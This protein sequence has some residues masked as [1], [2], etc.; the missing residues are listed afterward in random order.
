MKKSP[1]CSLALPLLALALCTGVSAQTPAPKGPP[2]PKINLPALSPT[3]SVKQ[4][5][6]LGDIAIDYARPSVKGRKIFG[7]LEPYGAV[8]RTGANTA[9]K[10]SF[11]MPVKLSLIHI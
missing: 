8:W 9:T 6:G 5:V 7:G 3:A 1:V 10:I 11:S 4:K 2:P